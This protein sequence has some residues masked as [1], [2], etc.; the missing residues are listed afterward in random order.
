MS[1]IYII[2]IGGTGAKCVE[3][4]THIAA[5]GILTNKSLKVLFVDPDEANGNLTRARQTI[6]VYNKCYNLISKGRQDVEQC[7]WMKTQIKLFKPDTWSPLNTDNVTLS[8]IFNYNNYQTSDKLGHPLKNIFDTL[9][10]PE[11]Q[12]LELNVGFRGRPAI[13]SVVMSQLN[14]TKKTLTEEPWQAFLQQ[15]KEDIIS[16]G[17]PEIFIYGSAFGGT[18][19]S[20]FPTIGRLIS[21][22]LEKEKIRQKIKL[23][24]A[25]LLPYF[26]FPPKPTSQQ[27]NLDESETQE[28][29]AQTEN[30]LL[31]TSAALRYYQVQ[32]KGSFDTIYL[33]GDQKLLQVN[34][35]FSLGRGNQKNDPHFLELYAAL[36]VQHFS[37]HSP[38]ERGEAVVIS[39]ETENIITWKDLPL[40]K[41]IKP[42]LV[43]MTR[44]AF[45]W[46][47]D[48]NQNVEKAKEVNFKNFHK[49]APWSIHFFSHSRGRK[50]LP[51]F[52]EELEN[53]MP[54]INQWCQTYL[55]W[56]G[57][58]NS[59]TGSGTEVKLFNYTNWMNDKEELSYHNDQ[60]YNLVIDGSPKDSNDTVQELMINLSSKNLRTPN[61]GLVGL[62][63]ALYIKC[64]NKR[65]S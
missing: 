6:K 65:R 60:F 35:K 8:S 52:S 5:A 2:A 23:G 34:Q 26:S 45:A 20:G 39:R 53:N 33:L 54:T 43:N 36:A 29:Y 32:A 7:P 58:L 59:T 19:A 48:I 14:L 15:V 49:Y 61:T 57:K 18:G 3:A 41:E 47:T 42:R 63:R 56:L 9:Y 17:T 24:G 31:N 21:N 46:M 25:L 13:G 38:N 30:F 4:L 37:N 62:A 27:D 50:N 28:I 1:S 11:E 40:N 51:D 12:E 22:K 55:K 64:K 16:S 44:F 10:T